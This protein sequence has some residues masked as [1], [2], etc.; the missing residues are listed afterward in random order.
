[1]KQIESHIYLRPDRLYLWLED[2]LA[3]NSTWKAEKSYSLEKRPI[4]ILKA[5]DKSQKIVFWSQMHGNEST[6]TYALTDLLLNL[7]EDKDF[8]NSLLDRYSIVII[9]MLNPDGAERFTRFNALGADLN[10]EGLRTI[11]PETEFLKNNLSRETFLAFNLHDQ[12]TLFSVGSTSTPATLSLLAPSAKT[13]HGESARI[14]AIKIISKAL[15]GLT[16]DFRKN[17]SR[18]SDEY[19]PLAL[20]EW[21]IDQGIATILVECG[22]Y[23]NDFH[24]LKS[25]EMCF[26]FLKNALLSLFDSENFVAAA[27]Y[28]L[29]ENSQNLRDVLLRNVKVQT[30]SGIKT[31]DLGFTAQ[32]IHAADRWDWHLEDV[33]DLQL[34]YGYVD[35]DMSNEESVNY[36]TVRPSSLYN[37]NDLPKSWHKWFTTT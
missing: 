9:P 30:P 2:F 31:L 8:R 24:R 22:G 17:I 29:P 33:G 34:K 7:E 20:G 1:M 37:L 36:L 13:Q 27:Y 18:F 12:R 16:P 6:C 26:L 14:T 21:C 35:A 3:Q 5:G 11:S 10:R 25:R 28:S 23:Y 19:Y 4:Y 15:E 32:Y